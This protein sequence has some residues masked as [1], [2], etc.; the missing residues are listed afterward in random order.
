M[1]KTKSKILII[2]DECSLRK[3]LAD[4]FTKEGFMVIEAK[5]GEE[6]L[7]LALKEKPDLILLDIIMPKMDGITMLGKLRED[8]WG[9]DVRVIIL[10][11]LEDEN[12]VMESVQKGAYD[13][14]IKSDWKLEDVVKKAKEKLASY[15]WL[16]TWLKH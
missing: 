4:K 12:K 15:Y 16:K 11:N 5:D 8:K 3:A 2:E 9:K 7:K 1:T 10:T 13:Y 6:G 14:L